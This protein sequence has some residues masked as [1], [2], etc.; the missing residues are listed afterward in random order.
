M[1]RCTGSGTTRAQ[2]TG[3]GVYG[4]A[5]NMMGDEALCYA[6][7]DDP[8]LV[9]DIMDSYMDFCCRLWERLC[10]GVAFDL[11]ESWEDMAS[12]NGSIISPAIFEEF[13]APN[14]QKMRRFADATGFPWCWWTATA[15]S[16]R[17]PADA[18]ER[19][20]RHVPLRGGGRVRPLPRPAELPGMAALG[21]LEKNACALGEEAIE[22]Q[23]ER[24]AG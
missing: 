18:R 8:D 11:I 2:L 5:R 9:H 4:F 15:T 7:Y 23:M 6:F 3:G 20:Q 13:L 10:D 12:K 17:W 22:E 16:T 1:S 21:C 14:F 24:H 19:R